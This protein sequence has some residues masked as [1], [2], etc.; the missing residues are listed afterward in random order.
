MKNLTIALTTARNEPN[1]HWFL[2]S[3]LRYL[4]ND[5][6]IDILVIDSRQ[7]GISVMGTIESHPNVR[8][9]SS[10][11][12]P[13]IW[14]GKYQITREPWWAKGAYLN[15]S[16]CLCETPWIAW[17]DD[18]AV[19]T[20]GWIGAIEDAMSG[21]YA[22]CGN[23]EKR[24]G[25]K[26]V[27]GEIIDEGRL[28]GKDTRTQ[29]EHPYRVTDWYGGSGALPLEWCLA[30][31]GASEDYCDSLG[32]EDSCFGITL[33]NSGYPI[34]YDSR[35]LIVEDRTPNEIDGAL[36]RSD[37]GSSPL[38]AS[39]AIIEVM[40]D[41]TTSQNSYDIRALRDRILAGE[42]WPPPTASHVHWFSGEDIATKFV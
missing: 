26:V 9:R 12:K 2:D 28:L 7:E 34:M 18:R 38:D 40:R 35:M 14:Q 11:V 3:L 5:C 25:M 10:G 42:P 29:H 23:Y 16:I 21:G 37:W 24:A 39:H 19:V 22:V 4:P 36:R 8:Y 33:R 20:P 30:V 27:N 6:E 1:V 13:T 15:S 17:C 41:K 31:N 32:S